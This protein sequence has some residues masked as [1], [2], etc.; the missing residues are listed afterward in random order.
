VFGRMNNILFQIKICLDMINLF[1]ILVS[2][3]HRVKLMKC[4]EAFSL[5]E[6]IET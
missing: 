5:A 4:Y 1:H 6:I 3:N 2:L